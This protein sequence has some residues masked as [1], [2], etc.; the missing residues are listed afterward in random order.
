MDSSNS[1][2]IRIPESLW[3]EFVPKIKSGIIAEYNMLSDRSPDEASAG[4][5]WMKAFL[6]YLKIVEKR[7]L[8][9]WQWVRENITGLMVISAVMAL[10]FGYL[11]Y[12]G[13][14]AGVDSN[15]AAQAAG[16]LDIAKLFAG[17]LVGAAGAT[18]VVK[19]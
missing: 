7:E 13:T 1:A 10:A 15:L 4:V 11:G 9:R 8:R 3:N 18:V 6:S 5:D 17:A 2:E 16:F 14:V 12:L 19:R